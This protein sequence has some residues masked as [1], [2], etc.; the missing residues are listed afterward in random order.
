[1]SSNRQELSRATHQKSASRAKGE[2]ILLVEDEAPVRKL[3]TRFLTL[4]GFEVLAAEGGQGALATWAEYKDEIDLLLTDVVMPGRWTGR[5]LAEQFQSEQP[6]LKVLYTSGYSAESLNAGG[7]LGD[8][9]N[10]L[11]K[12]YRPEQLLD[13]V[14]A[15][16]A[17]T[18]NTNAQSLC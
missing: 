8:E 5:A 14:R 13:A 4:S 17:G 3:V 15:V 6:A 16:L 7:A 2:T 10:F 18:F 9:I 1:M 12:P 11:Q